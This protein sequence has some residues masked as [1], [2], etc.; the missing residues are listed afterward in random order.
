MTCTAGSCLDGADNIKLEHDRMAFPARLAIPLGQGASWGW[1]KELTMARQKPVWES[2][3]ACFKENSFARI[4]FN[5]VTNTE[6]FGLR[7]DW[8]KN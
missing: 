8:K 4:P 7:I 6:A 3:F 5:P 2:Y 1:R